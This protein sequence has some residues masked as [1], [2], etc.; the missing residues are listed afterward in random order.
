MAV[1]LERERTRGEA[2]NHH[3]PGGRK[4]GVATTIWGRRDPKRWSR[5]RPDPFKTRRLARPR[6]RGGP[7]QGSSAGGS[8]GRSRGRRGRI[9]GLHPGDGADEAVAPG[10]RGGGRGPGTVASL[11]W[12]S[13]ERCRR[14]QEVGRAA[15]ARRGDGAAGVGR[16]AA[17]G[18][19][20]HAE[21]SRARRAMEASGA[22]AVRA[23][24]L[25]G[26][27]GGGGRGGQAREMA[28]R[29]RGEARE[30]RRGVTASRGGREMGIERAGLSLLSV[31]VRDGGKRMEGIDGSW[32]S[33]AGCG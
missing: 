3:V 9:E 13:T 24:E 7:E 20:T 1:A 32:G 28:A 6:C 4:L 29:G 23:D 10:R 26:P 30:E 11:R 25:A 18:G 33:G 2:E 12:L 22:M 14:E 27:R 21:G 16:T 19:E 8:A 5:T 31:C 15:L 17:L